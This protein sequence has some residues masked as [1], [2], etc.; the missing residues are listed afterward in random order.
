MIAPVEALAGRPVTPWRPINTS[1]AAAGVARLKAEVVGNVTA[2]TSVYATQ[3]LRL[4][5]P[6]VRG[7]SF[8]AYLASFG[9]GCVAG[10]QTRLD[11]RLGPGT[12]GFVGTQSSS[13]VYRNPE[14]RPTGHRTSAHLGRGSLLVWAPDP[15]QAFTDAVYDQ[16][17]EFH[18]DAGAGLVM[19]DCLSAGRV[20]SGERWAF[21][22]FASR[23][24]IRVEGRTRWLDRQRLDPGDGA[25]E[26]PYRMGRFNALA[27]AVVIG[28][29][30]RAMSARLLRD[31]AE[32]PVAR[33]R[34]SLITTVS[35]LDDG[36]LLR[37]AGEQLESVMHELRR[38]LTF[39]ASLLGEDP[40]TRKG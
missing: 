14:A 20:A 38:R 33:R 6:V 40:W 35:P 28:E 25:L 18:L 4:L 34:A 23:N 37:V 10:D 3:P 2:V 32:E 7:S 13:K 21:T 24:E 5:V 30:L 15:V 31:M 8:L 1:V 27:L 29:P 26:A 16:Q 19:W 17:Q 39:V 22:R 9:G 11:L 12:R 36:V